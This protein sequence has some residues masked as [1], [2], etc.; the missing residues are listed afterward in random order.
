MKMR[1]DNFL[2]EHRNILQI[3][4]ALKAFIVMGFFSSSRFIVH[5][6]SITRLLPFAHNHLVGEVDGIES[7]NW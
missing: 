5:K 6:L 1:M 7:G 2:K 3:E 4:I